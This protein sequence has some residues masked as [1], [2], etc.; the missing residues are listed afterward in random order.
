[1]DYQLPR[2]TPAVKYLLIAYGIMFLLSIFMPV[3]QTFLML[4]IQA[5]QPLDPTIL[6]RVFTY[7]FVNGIDNSLGFLFFALFLWWV[8]SSLEYQW[9]TRT[10]LLFLAV[11]SSVGGIV[12]LLILN[13]VFPGI[14]VIGTLGITFAMVSVFAFMIPETPFYVFGMFPLKAKWL[15]L[16]ILVLTFLSPSPAQILYALVIQVVT[17][18]VAIAFVMI[19]F[20][21]PYWLSSFLQRFNARDPFRK[22]F[23]KNNIRIFKNPESEKRGEK[24]PDR[25]ALDAS[26]KK[27]VRMDIEKLM[28][29]IRKESKDEDKDGK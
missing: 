10:F 12:S 13:A 4:Y 15:T 18:L 9:G 17:A 29:R 1:M 23:G 20:P 14:P 5:A 8:G 22:K 3:I 24:N 27:K 7:T 21:L 25:Q 28:E 26:T 2:M 11:T 6:Y 19:R 16:I